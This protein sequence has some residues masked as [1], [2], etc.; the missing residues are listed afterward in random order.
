MT[1][2]VFEL[3]QKTERKKVMENLKRVPLPSQLQST[4]SSKKFNPLHL[5]VFKNESNLPIPV[6]K[7]THYL[8]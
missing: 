8:G 5:V 7:L 2:V 6:I 1:R 4:T 3:R